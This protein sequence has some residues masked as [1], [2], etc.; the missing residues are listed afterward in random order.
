MAV[1]KVLRGIHVDDEARLVKARVILDESGKVKELR[2]VERAKNTFY[3]GDIFE[4]EVDLSRLNTGNA[5]KFELLP[6]YDTSSLPKREQEADDGLE[7]MTIPALKKMA[8]AEEIDLGDAQ[9]K[10]EIINVI[11]L[12]QG[13]PVEA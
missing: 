4:S 8:E 5:R 6:G 11:R 10:T 12:T 3:S 7:K 2:E 1:W 13:Q 9:N